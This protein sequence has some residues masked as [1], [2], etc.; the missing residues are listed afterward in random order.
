MSAALRDFLLAFADDEHLAGQ[1]HTEWIGV[2]PF[3]EEDLAFSSI[4]QD[5]LGHA[6]MLYELVLELDMIEPT[7]SAI[8]GIAFGRPPIAF[9][10]SA[11]SEYTTTDWSEA[12][13]RHWLYDEAERLRWRNVSASAYAPLAQ[14]AGRAMPEEE[15]HRRHAAAL[16]EPLLAGRNAATRLQAALDRLLPLVPTVL[17]AVDHEDELVGAGVIEQRTDALLHQLADAI[18]ARFDRP[19]ELP[20][21]PPGRHRRSGGFAALLA[22]MREVLDLDPQA[23]W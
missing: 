6:A 1:Q 5:E 7:D 18:A 4:A 19:I 20:A 8:D 11:L 10:S 23:T 14:A 17:A 9:R 13:V 12:L 16:I 3:L 21:P 22:R 15:F 2:A